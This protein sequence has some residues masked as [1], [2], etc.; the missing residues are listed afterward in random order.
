MTSAQLELPQKV[1][2]IPAGEV[3]SLMRRLHSELGEFAARADAASARAA[4]LERYIADEGIEPETGTWMLHRLQQHLVDV[5]AEWRSEV[6]FTAVTTRWRVDQMLERGSARPL[7]SYSGAIGQPASRWFDH[8]APE[9]IRWSL[10][11]C[12]TSSEALPAE[13]VSVPVWEP[14][15]VES[16]APRTEPEFWISTPTQGWWK[17]AARPSVVLQTAAGVAAATAILI[18]LA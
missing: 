11:D 17:R 14:P 6:S 3:E 10:A 5:R 1:E 2:I 4:R 7:V 18:H 8:S 15:E 9:S 16:D 13:L 12:G